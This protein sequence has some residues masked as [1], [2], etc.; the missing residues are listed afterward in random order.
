MFTIRGATIRRHIELRFGDKWTKRLTRPTTPRSFFA[1]LDKR[2][3]MW[4]RLIEIHGLETE[5]YPEFGKLNARSLAESAGVA[6]PQLLDGPIGV[7]ELRLEEYGDDFV[8]KPDWGASSRG[9]LVLRRQSDDSFLELISDTMLSSSEIR[10]RL[11]SAIDASGRGST[12]NLIVESSMADGDTL[13]T[14]WKVYTFYGRVGLVLQIDRSGT[15]RSKAYSADWKDLGRVR[16]DTAFSSALPGPSDPAGIL[17]AA[18][19]I[20]TKVPTGF[21][22]VDL[23]EAPHDGGVVFGELSLV[24]GGDQFYRRGVDR[25]LADLWDDA[26]VRL[27]TEQKPLIP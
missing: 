22:R 16:G 15:R 23:Y 4:N 2:F 6:T 5:L 10:E 7:S 8:I 25:T 3:A 14:D 13:P 27:M 21:M 19:A 18:S 12:T 9:V 26:E 20:S 17:A 11:T 1:Y 24:P